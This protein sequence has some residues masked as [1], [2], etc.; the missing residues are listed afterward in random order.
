MSISEAAILLKDIQGEKSL[1]IIG[2]LFKSPDKPVYQGELLLTIIPKVKAV[3][4]KDGKPAHNYQLSSDP[5]VTLF[6]TEDD[7]API[8]DYE[9]HLLSGVKSRD[10]RYKVFQKDLLDWGSKLREGTFV[11][12]AL[13]SKS[14]LS[15]QH[16]VS[17]IK[18]IGPLPNERGIQFGVE[19][20]V[21]GT[22]MTNLV[23]VIPCI[24]I[25]IN[26]KSSTAIK[27]VVTDFLVVSNILN[28]RRTVPSLYHL[29]DSCPW[30]L[31]NRIPRSLSCL[32]LLIHRDSTL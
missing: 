13:P 5:A 23:V 28:V 15:G 1:G 12:V 11:N 14:P 10:V 30:S 26:R 4:R 27:A 6:C 16:A 19:I 24:I 8:S 25:L 3:P 32:Q 29:I 18:Y 22:Y 21:S 17:V 7:M 9:Y 2:G 20:Q 31:Y